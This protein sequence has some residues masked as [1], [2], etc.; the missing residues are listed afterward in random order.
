MTGDDWVKII[1]AIGTL[2][3]V[4]LSGIAAVYAAKSKAICQQNTEAIAKVSTIGDDNSKA[5]A[6]VHQLTNGMSERLVQQGTDAGFKAG[7]A[8]EKDKSQQ[9]P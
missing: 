6:E 2:A 8:S 9:K 5:I 7:V 3:G 1:T 4:V